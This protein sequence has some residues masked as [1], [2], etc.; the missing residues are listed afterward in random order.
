VHRVLELDLAQQ[1]VRIFGGGYAAYLEE[2]ERAKR[3]A[4]E[5]YEEYAD[6]RAGLE[7][8]MRTQIGWADKGVREAKSKATDNDK[9]RL[10][11]Q[12]ARSEKLAGKVKATERMLERLDVVEEPR[13]EWELRM[14]IAAAPAPG[15]WWRRCARR[16]C[17]AASSR[18]GRSACRSTGPTGSRSPG[19]TARASPR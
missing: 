6:T 5:S 14:E 18:S 15:R 2:R 8:R 11:A 3:Q 9:H 16:S 7:G 4:R 13:K 1:Q 17:A 10:H 19:R 12:V